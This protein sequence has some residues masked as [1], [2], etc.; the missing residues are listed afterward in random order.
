LIAFLV[1]TAFGKP[2]DADL[3]YFVLVDRFANGDPANDGG[4]DR[5][6]PQAF[7]GGDLAGVQDRLGHLE[8][9]GVDAIWLSPIFPMR[10][11][12]FMGHGAFHGYWVSHMDSIAPGFGGERALRALSTEMQKKEIHLVMDM[13]YNHVSFDSP[14][15]E[16]HPD[17]FHPAFPIEDWGDP[18]QLEQNQVHGLPDFDQSRPPVYR[19]LLHRSRHWQNVA[20]ASGLRIDAVRHMDSAFLAQLAGD[21]HSGEGP[22]AWLLG[23]DFQGSPTKLAIR[24]RETGLDALF[25][26]PLYYAMADVFCD[27]K[28][29]AGLAATLSADRHYPEGLQLVTFMDNHDLPRLVSRCHGDQDKAMQALLFQF[30]A[31]GLPMLTYGTEFLLQGSA[32]PDNRGSIHW[33]SQ[34]R[35]VG[36]IGLLSKLREDHP[37]LA[38]GKGRILLVEERQLVYSQ[39]L[40]GEL[41]L[42]LVNGGEKKMAIP[43]LGIPLAAVEASDGI[44]GIDMGTEAVPPGSTQLWIFATEES[45]PER[46][47]STF[48]FRV[49]APQEGEVRIA[50][51]AEEL[52]GWDAAEALPLH[53]SGSAWIGALDLPAGV[54]SEWKAVQVTVDGERWEKSGNHLLWKTR[55]NRAKIEA[56]D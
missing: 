6:D 10:T 1:G 29:T 33:E 39:R 22:A 47:G 40:D 43:N 30:G 48:H 27:G 17:W 56:E 55:E 25:D 50:G 46:E 9:M 21:L 41:S 49:D 31:R 23:E 18:V 20:G 8:E 52:G 36:E 4:T 11:E 3:L 16:A 51:T 42:L 28:S 45:I 53:W 38:R 7:H 54:A 15:V 44:A 26:F 19:Y 37:V 2:L 34:P 24:A 5:Q 14:M 35:L 12:K 13:V 32:E